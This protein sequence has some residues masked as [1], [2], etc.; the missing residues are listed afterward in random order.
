MAK[1][2]NTINWSPVQTTCPICK[3][4]FFS[5]PDHAWKI[6]ET[7]HAKKVCSYTCMR[8]W[9]KENYYK[10]RGDTVEKKA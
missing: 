5:T 10:R 8:K 9:E 7:I 3:K 2:N 6:G 4:K 1:D